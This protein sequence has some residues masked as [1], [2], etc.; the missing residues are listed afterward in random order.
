MPITRE[1][2]AIELAEFFRDGLAEDRIGVCDWVAQGNYDVDEFLAA[3]NREFPKIAAL[4]VPASRK[5]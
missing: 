5:G 3:L 1:Q 2:I 4:P